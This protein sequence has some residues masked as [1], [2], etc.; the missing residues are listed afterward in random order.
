MKFKNPWGKGGQYFPEHLDKSISRWFIDDANAELELSDENEIIEAE[1]KKVAIA[2]YGGARTIGDNGSFKIAATNTQ[3]S[4]KSVYK[5]SLHFA[6]SGQFIVDTINDVS[7]DSI[8][9]LDIITHAS[10]TAAY[11][12]RNKETK[13]SGE[14]KTIPEDQVESNNMYASS[15]AK[16]IES[17][18]AGDDEVTIYD[19]EFK[20]FAN[21]AVVELHGCKVATTPYELV[22]DNLAQN[23]SEELYSEEKKEAVVIGHATKANPNINGTNTKDKDQDY[24]H[25]ERIIYHNGSV[26]FRTK[27][28]KHIGKDVVKKYLGKKNSEGG[29]YDGNKQEYKKGK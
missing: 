2:F 17:W 10:A 12:V 26:L 24:R 15:T 11:M 21:D 4:Y 27:E 29:E 13:D 8:G 28:K 19:I 16:G 5:N 3:I 25:G 6:K 20:K 22:I 14:A 23:L 1:T 18:G 9:R 7:D